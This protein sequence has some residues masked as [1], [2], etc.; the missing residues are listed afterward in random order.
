MR[1]ETTRTAL[2]IAVMALAGLAAAG[3]VE[4][5]LLIRSEPAGAPVWI[6]EVRV[7]QTPLTYSFTHYGERRIRVGPLRDEADTL[8]YTE[9]EGIVRLAAPWYERFPLGFFAEVL[10]PAKLTDEHRV[11]FELQPASA[12]A[13]HYGEERAREEVKRAEEFRQKAL[14]PVPEEQ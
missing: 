4:R 8:T 5:R 14:S 12:G 7:G 3:C 2:F 10:W 11:A 6:D 9:T 13:R 1:I